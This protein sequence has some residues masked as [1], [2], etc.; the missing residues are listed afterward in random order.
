MPLYGS[1]LT[2]S[3]RGL[4]Y[5]GGC[6]DTTPIRDVVVCKGYFY[7]LTEREIIIFDHLL[8]RAGTVAIEAALNLVGA[9][10]HLVVAY[11]DR[12]DVLDLT[13]PSAPRAV[14]QVG[15]RTVRCLEPAA[16]GGTSQSVLVETGDGH[17]S[18]VDA[19]NGQPRITATYMARPWFAGAAT[20]RDIT[21]CPAGG[22]DVNIFSSGKRA[23]Q[24]F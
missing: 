4:I 12:L 24:R 7:A 21:L 19:A 17:F 8:R 2:W 13:T 11:R 3:D 20:M 15:I 22:G 9:G 10:T 16:F 23:T 18:L 5:N 1:L 6:I 14:G